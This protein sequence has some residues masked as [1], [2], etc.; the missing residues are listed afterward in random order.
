LCTITILEAVFV[1]TICP[2]FNGRSD[3]SL[4]ALAQLFDAFLIDDGGQMGSILISL[5]EV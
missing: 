3:E 1:D 4:T 2:P 5:S